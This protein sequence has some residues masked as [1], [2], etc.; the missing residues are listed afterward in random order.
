MGIPTIGYGHTGSD[1]YMGMPPITKQRAEELL[2]KDLRENMNLLLKL[3]PNVI[4]A[5]T[6]R[7]AALC[8]LIF[9]IGID[10]YRSSTL[11]ICVERKEWY[12]ASREMQRWVFSGGQKIPGLV[13]RRQEEARMLV[14]WWDHVTSIFYALFM[15]VSNTCQGDLDVGE[16]DFSDSWD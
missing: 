2:E 1:V 6:N 16:L 11:R 4:D 9:N 14:G 8:D 10:A 13:V 12:A 5:G 3:S 15:G 7:I